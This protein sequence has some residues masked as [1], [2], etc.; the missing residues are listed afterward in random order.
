MIIVIGEI[1]QLISLV[2][3]ANAFLQGQK[4]SFDLDHS[5]AQF[6]LS[7]E[8]IGIISS[9]THEKRVVISENPND[10]FDFLQAQG[11]ERIRL[12]YVYPSSEEPPGRIS[13][14]FCGGGG[15]WVME[16]IQGGTNILWEAGWKTAMA[17]GNRLW[18]VVY[19]ILA[20]DW[21]TPVTDII[22]VA[23][24]H[25]KL[26][27]ALQEIESFANNDEQQL[28]ADLF[29][30]G[31]TALVADN[32]FSE[33]DD[34]PVGCLSNEAEQ[35]IAACYPSWVFEG[36]GSWN[37]IWLKEE[38]KQNEYDRVSDNLYEALCTSIVAGVNS[39]PARE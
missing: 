36:M 9:G 31:H 26:T 18:K 11:V 5:S 1:A 39:Y 2:T 12:H 29:H 13:A 37:D 16:T 20:K 27:S 22:T 38:K 4:V 24:A 17:R 7:I 32:P 19:F 28:W 15:R 35:L 25:E 14:A 3:Y 34:L 10:W 33:S 21:E 6:C 8:F 23:K 30:K